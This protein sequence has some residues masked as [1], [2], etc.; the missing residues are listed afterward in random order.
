MVH[1]IL[2]SVVEFYLNFVT[3]AGCAARSFTYDASSNIATRSRT[4]GL[5]MTFQYDVEGRP[6]REFQT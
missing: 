1:F 5:G 6:S 3:K 2:T 4:G